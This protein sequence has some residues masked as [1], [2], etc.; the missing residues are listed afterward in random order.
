MLGKDRAKKLAKLA[1]GKGRRE[2]DRILLDSLPLVERALELGAL[3]EVI[4]EEGRHEDLVARAAA[5]GVIVTPAIADVLRK[6][7]GVETSPGVVGVGRRRPPVDLATLAA[8][9]RLRLVYC[10]RI[11]DPGNLGTI[12]R[13]AAAFGFDAL[14]AS[15]GSADPES[16]KALRAS[17]GAFLHL[18]WARAELEEAV[19]SLGDVLV[20]RTVVRGGKPLRTLAPA[21]RALLWLGNEAQGVTSAPPGLRV[22]DLSIE[23]SSEVESLNVGAAAAILCHA[24]FE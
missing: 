1:T 3:E 11:S 7:A 15:E 24:L 19:E 10:E 17:A 20:Y 14:V 23:M 9:P 2:Q 8:R 13:A 5:S 4:V 12:A 6:V 16:P 21:A 18:P 22:E